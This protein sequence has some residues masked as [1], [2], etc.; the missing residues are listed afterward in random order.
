M[1]NKTAPN[2]SQDQDQDFSQLSEEDWKARLDPE[3]YEVLRNSATE[4]PF[5]GEYVDNKQTGEYMCGACGQV[6]FSSKTKFDSGSGWPSFYDVTK[7]GT[8]EIRDDHS[9]GMHRQEVICS[10]CESHLGHLFADGPQDTTGMRYCINSVALD[11]KPKSWGHGLM[12][13]HK[14][15][16]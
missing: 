16:P 11:F 8:V 1:S 14:V 15:Q 3:A 5:T 2:P 10:R 13:D 9:H 7:E 12:K 6:L 4:R